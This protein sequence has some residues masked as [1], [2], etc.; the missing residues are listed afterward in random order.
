M[1][2]YVNLLLLLTMFGSTCY[3]YYRLKKFFY[4]ISIIMDSEIL[5]QLTNLG[6]D[7]DS[8]FPKPKRSRKKKADTKINE[9]EDNDIR[10]KR[11]RLVACVLSGNSKM[12][13]GKEYTEEQINE[14]DCTNVNTLLNRYESVLSA[15]MTKSLGKS[16]IN[17][18]SNIACSVLGVGNQQELSTNLACDPFL[19]TA[20]KRFR[21]DLYYRFG[22]LL[23]LVSVGIITGKHYAKNSITKLNDRSNNGTCDTVT[24]NV[25]KQKNP[26]RVE[27]GRK[28]V[29]YNKRKKEELKRLNEQI[30]NQ[31]DMAEH[32]PKSD[33]NTYV[34]VGGLSVFGLAI[35]GYLLYSKFKKQEQN[36]IDV[37]PP[38]VPKTSTEPKRDIFEML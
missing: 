6:R 15:Q 20:M 30:T 34:Y 32:K 36:L 12:Y 33:T 25:T 23:A 18:Y 3:V 1:I 10:D 37:P 17:L 2:E 16:L 14:K 22:G 27:Q 26:L 19:N 28:L 24:R 13:L 7:V 8:E 9:L 35:G 5:D 11:E 21:C 38:P 31:D 4:L 29:E